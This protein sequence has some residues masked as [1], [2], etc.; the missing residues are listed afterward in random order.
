MITRKSL[1]TVSLG[2]ALCS[3]GNCA[4]ADSVAPIPTVSV[5]TSVEAVQVRVGE[6]QQIS[7]T[8]RDAAGVAIPN[9]PITWTSQTPAVAT[10]TNGLVAGIARGRTAVIA[11]SE[12]REASVSVNVVSDIVSVEV[13]PSTLALQIGESRDL[14]TTL[15]NIAGAV[16]SG[17]QVIWSTNDAGVAAVNAAGR[18]TAIA[19]G[20][21]SV[22]ATSEDRVG[23][24]SVQVLAPVS[25]VTISPATVTLLIGGTQQ[26]TTTLK[27]AAGVTLVGRTVTWHSS[28]TSRVVVSTSGLVTA[29][30][31]G[32]AVVTASSESKSGSA[33]IVVAPP[34]ATV[35]ITPSTASVFIGNTQQLTATLRA[36]NGQVLSGRSV[37][38]SSSDPNKATVSSQGVV[39]AVAAGSAAISAVSEGITGTAAVTVPPAVSSVQVSPSSFSIAIGQTQQLTVLLRSAAGDTLSGRSISFASSDTTK[40]KVSAT[41][42]VSAVATGTVTITAA[43]EGK[44]SSA[45]GT[46]LAV[47]PV[48]LISVTPNQA[49]VFVDDSVKMTAV[50]RDANNAI[51]TNASFTWSV[52]TSVMFPY[53]PA[54]FYADVGPTGWIY[55]KMAS[56]VCNLSGTLSTV[57]ELKVTATSTTTT[58][59]SGSTSFVVL[60]KVSTGYLSPRSLVLAKQSSGVLRA[61]GGCITYVGAT[62]TSSDSSVATVQDSVV[63]GKS[64]GSA[65]IKAEFRGVRDSIQASVLDSLDVTAV[66][67]CEAGW[68]LCYTSKI[69][70]GTNSVSVVASASGSGI[71]LTA[72]CIFSWVATDPAIVSVQPSSD[73]RSAVITRRATG[74]T[75]VRVSCNGKTASFN[76]N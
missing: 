15:K 72:Q 28:D 42:V 55:G 44:S 45:T 33:A 2:L 6:T 21:V 22:S 20:T 62:R 29:K 31:E 24:A 8:P 10:V 74:A 60:P 7:A 1:G 16:L 46:I 13:S 3:I 71:D 37:S 58:E 26:L 41:G 52:G 34:V 40:A 4:T 66:A 47:P 18:V 48:A 25:S 36:A 49:S 23:T 11:S 59:K 27:D 35:S 57:D 12:G 38:W 63:T 54:S 14:T 64:R 69:L 68:S 61:K 70:L 19:P 39:T 51:I 43:S 75:S 76:V 9:R 73:F 67:V 30:K 5:T 65:W 56:S 32:D 17:R 53:K 50:A